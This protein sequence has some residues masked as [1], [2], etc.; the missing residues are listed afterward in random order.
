LAINDDNNNK[1]KRRRSRF[2]EVDQLQKKL[3]AARKKAELDRSNSL[4]AEN[5]NDELTRTLLAKAL[6]ERLANRDIFS[7]G[8]SFI[9]GS[10]QSLHS[11]MWKGKESQNI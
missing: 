2:A 4:T 5:A 8:R 11:G 10:M 3:Q 6:R 1:K 7:E 9:H